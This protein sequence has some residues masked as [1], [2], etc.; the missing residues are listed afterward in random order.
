[1]TGL[2]PAPIGSLVLTPATGFNDIGSF[3]ASV[4]WVNP[5]ASAYGARGDGVADATKALKA[6]LAAAANNVLVI[7]A[8]EYLFTSQLIIP[9]QTTV[10]LSPGVTLSCGVT[11]GSSGILISEGAKL[12]GFGGA[13]NGSATP[14]CGIHTINGANVDA[15]ITNY[16]HTIQEFAFLEHV[17]VYA[18]TGSTLNSLVDFV[19]LYGHSRM[20]GCV[21]NGNFFAT[22]VFRMRAGTTNGGGQM[23]FVNNWFT[24]AA[25]NCISIE[26]TTGSGPSDLWFQ[27]NLIEHWGSG[28][29][30]VN[31]DGSLNAPVSI[32]FDACHWEMASAPAATSYCVFAAGCVG[33]SVENSAFFTPSAT[34]LEGI[35]WTSTTANSGGRIRNFHASRSITNILNDARNSVTRTGAHIESYQQG[36][37]SGDNYFADK[38][39]SA[40]GIGVGNSAAGSSLGTVVKKVQIF[41]AAGSSL[42]YVPVY[43]AIT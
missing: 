5:T 35:H 23:S 15:L 11:D 43:D 18:D 12:A 32:A 6:A 9:E 33:L 31:I 13:G 30:G 34:N 17:G 41:D 2:T 36:H 1:M 21:L 26:G 39:L 29:A 19:A 3:A 20:Q 8:G 10:L 27:H 14:R 22:N 16:N 40:G 28:H 7:P 38:V 24:N 25:Q 4:G 42:G 37:Q